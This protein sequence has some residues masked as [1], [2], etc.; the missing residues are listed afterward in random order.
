[1]ESHLNIAR[2]NEEVHTKTLHLI[3]CDF[4]LEL[5]D[6]FFLT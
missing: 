2:C 4:N 5:L 1:M 6:V 3:N